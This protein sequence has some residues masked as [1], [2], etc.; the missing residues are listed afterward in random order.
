MAFNGRINP[1]RF[2]RAQA[3][4]YA[5]FVC[6]A[7]TNCAVWRDDASLTVSW[8]KPNT[9]GQTLENYVVSYSSDGGSNWTI[10]SSSV[11]ADDTAYDITGL[12]NGTT[13]ICSIQAVTWKAGLRGLTGSMAPAASLGYSVT[14]SPGETKYYSITDA[15][16]GVGYKK[17]YV[18][19]TGSGSITFTTNPSSV[20]VTAATVAGGGGAGR[21]GASYGGGGGGGGQNSEHTIGHLD[22]TSNTLTVTIGGGGAYGGGSGDPNSGSDTT[23]TNSGG[24]ATLT[25]KGGGRGGNGWS[26]ASP[27]AGSA[28][29]SS[30]G[31]GGGGIYGGQKGYSGGAT[32]G[33]NGGEGAANWSYGARLGGAG[34]G[35]GAV[36]GNGYAYTYGGGTSYGGYGGT[37]IY[38]RYGNTGFTMGGGGGGGGMQNSG[39][40]TYLFTSYGY[41]GGGNGYTS[42]YYG[43]TPVSPQGSDGVANYG[44]GGGG[45]G[46]NNDGGNGSSGVVILSWEV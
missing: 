5:P 12:T 22:V 42:G 44:G 32:Y 43:A 26:G 45:G 33:N 4:G 14:G 13:Y 36:G 9:K 35:M 31:S 24:A 20:S 11:S 6:E 21:T 1:K 46:Y 16:D 40:A 38:R 25:A 34:G 39:G 28:S 10:A 8:K 3:Q 37:G 30:Y 18:R 27:H 29:G 41:G 19:F 15:V 2:R 7:P 23:I 17:Q